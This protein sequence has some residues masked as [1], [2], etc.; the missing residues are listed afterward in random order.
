MQVSVVMC[1]YNRANYIGEAL[2]ALYNQH[3]SY[4]HYEVLIVDNN[5]SDNTK[6]VYDHWRINHPLGN[7]Y[8]YT[9][10]Q[11][12][13][14]FARNTGAALSKG[15]WLCFVDDD[16][17][18]DSRFIANIIKH[19]ETHPTIVGFGGKIIPRYIP[20]EPKWMSYYVSS[21]VGNF[22][23]APFAK[24]FE[25]NKYPLESNMIIKKS[26]YN[27][28]GG[29]N[30]QLPGVVGTKRIG[31]EGKEL[32]FKIMKLGHVIY[33]DPSIQV[34][35]VVEVSKLTKEYMYRVASGMGRG[36]KNRT[37]AIG[38]IAYIKKIFEY[39]LKLGAAIIL[40]MGYAL[41]GN[42]S[43]TLPIIQFRIDTLKGLIGL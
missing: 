16:A 9:E 30:T 18:V 28:V 39:V 25:N 8:Y 42:P 21:I 41:K 34:E 43:Q 36:E 20:S 14:S 29:F 33:Y 12:G 17:I 2:T 11:Q 22:D 10:K 31:G 3:V 6:E 40:G 37:L 38:Y 27:Q 13:A 32:F 24:P 1:S 26:V 7:F 35:H 19:T 5:S 4:E 15:N 23:Y